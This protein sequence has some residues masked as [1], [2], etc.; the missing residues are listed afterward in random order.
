MK[1]A[2][3]HDLP[4]TPK[5]ALWALALSMFTVGTGSLIVLGIGQEVT[6]AFNL[7]SGAA[8][9][10]MTVFAG[11]FAVAAPLAQL[12]LAKRFSQLKLVGLGLLLLAAGMLWASLATSYSSLLAARTVMALG[13]ALIAPA[14]AAFAVQLSLPK[15][16]TQALAT[17][18]AGFTL[19]SVAG[20]PL[21]TWLGVAFGWRGTM[22]AIACLAVIALA[23][24]I[25]CFRTL[26]QGRAPDEESKTPLQRSARNN[27]LAILAT[28]AGVLS[29]QFAIYAVMAAFLLE[30]FGLTSNALPVV[31]LFFGI[32]GVAG[33]A[34]SGV[35]ADRA[36][37]EAVIWLSL[38]GL[39][40]MTAALL[41]DL[42]PAFASILVAGCAFCGTLFTAPQQARLTMVVPAR[43]HGL[44][45]ALNSSASYIGITIGSATAS[46]LYAAFGVGSLPAGALA[47]LAMSAVLNL[48]ASSKARPAD[49]PG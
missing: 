49:T 8:G 32:A 42:G 36:G 17:V 9:W 33:N 38:A 6:E 29:A 44:A 11:V 31:M 3:G 27:A 18:F 30:G 15:H 16:R 12:V 40:V 4:K 22:L 26:Q 7:P 47:L 2:A 37:I 14:S 5:Q 48:A 45:L 13:G 24:V 23:I 41:A 20:V 25:A 10:L 1:P 35:W 39:A 21:G 34:V 28:T 19:A 43:Y 46:L